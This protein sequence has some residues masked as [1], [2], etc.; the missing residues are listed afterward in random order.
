MA[1]ENKKTMVTVSRGFMTLERNESNF[2]NVILFLQFQNF[3]RTLIFV[4]QAFPPDSQ[5]QT[6][7]DLGKI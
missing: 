4:N 3:S 6:F 1:D 5:P 7:A 2:L